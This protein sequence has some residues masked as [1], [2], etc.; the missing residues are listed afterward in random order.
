MPPPQICFSACS[1]GQAA[2]L[3]CAHRRSQ[4]SQG[5]PPYTISLLQQNNFTF[6]H[7]FFFVIHKWIQSRSNPYPV[8][9]GYHSPSSHS[10]LVTYWHLHDCLLDPA[11]S[12]PASWAC[13][14]DGGFRAPQPLQTVLVSLATPFAEVRFKQPISQSGSGLQT[15]GTHAG[16]AV[17]ALNQVQQFNDRSAQTLS[18]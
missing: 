7:Y 1:C 5:P 9:F 17:N 8:I 4:M 12:S 16:F 13:L 10:P 18:T 11:P 15:S 2:K 3:P 14:Q 6:K